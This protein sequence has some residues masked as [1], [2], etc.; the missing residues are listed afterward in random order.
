MRMTTK[1]RRNGSLKD[2]VVVADGI[3]KAMDVT[4]SIGQDGF[5]L[6][7]LCELFTNKPCVGNLLL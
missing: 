4:V 7:C 3:D 1:K 2:R 5:G 6:Y